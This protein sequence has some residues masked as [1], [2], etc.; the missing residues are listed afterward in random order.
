MGVSVGVSVSIG[1]GV[2]LGVSDGVGV[3]V[4]I[5]VNVGVMVGVSLGK[6]VGVRVTAGRSMGPLVPNP[7]SSRKIQP[8]SYCR[9]AA[10]GWLGAICSQVASSLRALKKRQ[11]STSRGSP[12]GGYMVPGPE[13]TLMRFA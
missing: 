8:P 4:G 7:S 9:S 1:G 3:E 2:S 13:R 12:S 11:V 5:R 6:G 10:S